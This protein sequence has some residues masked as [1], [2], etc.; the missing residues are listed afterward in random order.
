MVESKG[1]GDDL[2]AYTSSVQFG[3]R[4]LDSL[5]ASVSPAVK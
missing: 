2:G 4:F 3:A 5:C 1:S